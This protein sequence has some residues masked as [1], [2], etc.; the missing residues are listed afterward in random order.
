MGLVTEGV[1]NLAMEI[2]RA[3]AEKESNTRTARESAIS[4]EKAITREKSVVKRLESTLQEL[5]RIKNEK[6]FEKYKELLLNRKKELEE[7]LLKSERQME[8]TKVL[9]REWMS[10]QL[11]F[12]ALFLNME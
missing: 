8:R 12:K 5:E 7:R 1:V 10:S 2:G 9:L 4:M 6:D 3:A 11:A